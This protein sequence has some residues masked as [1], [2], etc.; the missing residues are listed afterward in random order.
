MDSH[1]GGPPFWPPFENLWDYYGW[2]LANYSITRCEICLK[3]EAQAG[4]GRDGDQIG[5]LSE[6]GS[7]WRVVGLILTISR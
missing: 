1:H 4:V 3:S 5:H 7:P 6:H 2:R